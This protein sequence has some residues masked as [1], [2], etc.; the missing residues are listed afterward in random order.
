MKWSLFSLVVGILITGN[1][2]VHAQNL[3]SISETPTIPNRIP[4]DA[5]RTL[6]A[7]P[8]QITQL[9]EDVQRQVARQQASLRDS[10]LRQGQNQ[11]AAARGGISLP[12][13]TPASSATTT[14]TPTE[15]STSHPSSGAGQSPLT[16]GRS[17]LSDANALNQANIAQT[18]SLA[19]ASDIR[20]WKSYYESE[21]DKLLETKRAYERIR[22]SLRRYKNQLDSMLGQLPTT[23]LSCTR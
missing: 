7:S 1:V 11:I 12:S 23:I 15:T 14:E 2:L 3:P 17:Y 9:P 5:L 18:L 13:P 8:E 6:D 4:E 19:T 20:L 22:D 10:I 21:Y 16:L